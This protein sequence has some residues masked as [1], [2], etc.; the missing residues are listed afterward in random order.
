MT[1]PFNENDDFTSIA[2][3]TVA[4]HIERGEYSE[5]LELADSLYS[6]A[7]EQSPENNMSLAVALGLKAKVYKAKGELKMA[8]EL[9]TESL[10]VLQRFNRYPALVIATIQHA[11]AN[12]YSAL[13]QNKE[14]AL[15]Y[16]CALL[17]YRQNQLQHS[18]SLFL[19]L[20]N[21]GDLFRKTGDYHAALEYLNEALPIARSLS[22]VQGN[23]HLNTVLNN[24]GLVYLSLGEYAKSEP[25]LREA[26]NNRQRDGQ[27][28]DSGY[29]M[30]ISNLAALYHAIGDYRAAEPILRKALEIIKQTEGEDHREYGLFL[31]NLGEVY[32]E[33]GNHS[34]AEKILTQALE[35]VQRSCGENHQD[36]HIVQGNLAELFLT[37]GDYC[38]AEQMLRRIVKKERQNNEIGHPI[39]AVHL[40]NLASICQRN[41][42]FDEAEQLRSEALLILERT[43]GEYHPDIASSLRELAILE[44]AIGRPDDAMTRLERA[45]SIDD[46]VIGQVFSVS[47]EKQ[48]MI[49]LDKLRISLHTFLSF[50]RQN[51][52]NSSSTV[53]KALELVLRRKCIGIEALAIQREN[54]LGGRYPHLKPKLRELTQIRWQIASIS[55]AGAASGGS[56]HYQV[57]ENFDSQDFSFKNETVFPRF[58]QLNEHI[59]TLADL[60]DRKSNLEVELARDIPQLDL[61]KRLQ[62]VSCNELVSALPREAAL[63]EF[64]RFID[65]DFVATDQK[66][67]VRP[68]R[69]LAF[70]LF[71]TAHP[72]VHMIDLGEA[73]QI[74]TLVGKVLSSFGRKRTSRSV[75]SILRSKILKPVLSLFRRRSHPRWSVSGQSMSAAEN[76]GTLLRKAVFDPLLECL[77]GRTRLFL[78]PDSELC[79]LPFEVLPADDGSHLIDNYVISYLSSGRDILRIDQP[80]PR[81]TSDP[82]V[83]ANPDFNLKA[84]KEALN[85]SAHESPDHAHKVR[86]YVHRF[87]S[88]WRLRPRRDARSH[89][90]RDYVHRFLSLEGTRKEGEQV[91]NML[92][93]EPWLQ[94]EALESRVKERRSPR[95]LH[96][97]THGFFFPDPEKDLATAFRTDTHFL[98]TPFGNIQEASRS[99]LLGPGMTNPL[100][101][102]CLVLAGANIWLNGGMLPP[103]A[104]DGLLTAEDVSGMDLQ[105]TD[106]VVLSACDTG[107]GEIRV[108]EGVFGLRRSFVVAGAKSLVMSLWKVPDEQT[109]ELMVDF[110]RRMLLGRKGELALREAQ[111]E[112]KS[113]H[114][115]PYYWGSFIFQGL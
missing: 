99:R 97:A 23:A 15:L 67:A 3:K 6:T 9:Y 89:K 37:K 91:A 113:K 28:N 70:V 92:K 48:R 74:D 40:Q 26:L 34:E 42:I 46:R 102:S 32:A 68:E 103:E 114:P 58:Q 71:A 82:L 105:N 19:T 35:R 79:R 41:R 14:A 10:E 81:E 51:F 47:S 45:N 61:Q 60:N 43:Y 7:T 4:E 11:L 75:S 39:F 115:D 57:T 65:F 64:V 85:I 100:L 109:C 77:G 66:K 83:V 44:T 53:E 95:I 52:S 56:Q 29:A 80:F 17:F 78:S 104:E 54:V 13:D 90:V 24:L 5:A 73:E 49:Y 111:L 18:D 108:G 16:H 20:N 55:L 36:F 2:Q 27:V 1:S 69:Y 101:R 72:I 107:V 33:L 63:I 96:F 22:Q 25:I 62:K 106:L 21:L 59:Q 88:R 31:S 94:A 110:Y 98:S 50:V 38:K 93:V 112:M 87:L 76:H 84:S 8:A 12:V 86:D 30:L